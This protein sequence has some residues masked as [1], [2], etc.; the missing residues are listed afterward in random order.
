MVVKVFIVLVD[1]SILF[2]CHTSTIKYE[3]AE[4][5]QRDKIVYPK[6]QLMVAC[7]VKTLVV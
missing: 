1:Y 5:Y 3:F 2:Y 7:D 6:C 4:T